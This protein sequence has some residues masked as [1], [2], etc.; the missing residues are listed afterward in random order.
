M[1]G[2]DVIGLALQK[3]D[4]L[5]HRQSVLAQNIAN[6]NT[7]G[8]RARDIAPFESVLSNT[9]TALAHTNPRHL[10]LDD[11]ARFTVKVT[12]AAARDA[13]YNRNSISVEAEM[14]KLGET[15][16]EFAFDTSIIKSFNHM[17]MLS[18]KA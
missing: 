1:P 14:L 2:Y 4:W 11:T 9:E 8:Y 15:H 10:A 6:A 7:P 18:L 3:S 5:A 16:S 17:L 12:E 13:T